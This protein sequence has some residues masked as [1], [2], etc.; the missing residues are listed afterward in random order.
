MSIG[1][2]YIGG[3][4]EDDQQRDGSHKT[5]KGASLIRSR[6][7]DAK[8][9]ETNE[10]TSDGRQHGSRRLNGHLQREM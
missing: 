3:D 10:G 4:R 5:N 1:F 7:E 8:E 6:K 9:E 2:L